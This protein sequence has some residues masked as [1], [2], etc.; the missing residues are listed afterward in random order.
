LTGGDRTLTEDLLQE[1]CLATVRAA[2]SGSTEDL[3]VGWMIVVARRRFV[4]H[5]RRT[6]REQS[7]L[8]TVGVAGEATEPDWDSIGSDQALDLLGRLTHDQRAA[9]IFRYI[10]DLAVR[11]V[12]ELLGRSVSATESLLARGRR[13]L[14][15]RALEGGH[16][17]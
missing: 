10:D 15:Q 5:L 2:R 14:T 16:N 17:G 7:R 11:E 9:L 3:T 12:A 13:E 8:A 1:T 4:D 6:Q